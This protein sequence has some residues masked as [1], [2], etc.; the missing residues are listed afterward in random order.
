MV[1]IDCMQSK[2][3]TLTSVLAIVPQAHTDKTSVDALE[4]KLCKGNNVVISCIW[5]ADT[6]HKFYCSASVVSVF[7]IKR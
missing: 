6:I 4:C 1:G 3:L 7:I 2:C 5:T